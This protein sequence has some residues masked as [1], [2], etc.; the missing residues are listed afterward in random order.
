MACSSL[1]AGCTSVVAWQQMGRTLVVGMVKSLAFVAW[2]QMAEHA[3]KS[4]L[5]AAK[6]VHD[7]PVMSVGK[8]AVAA[9]MGSRTWVSDDFIDRN[10]AS[11]TGNS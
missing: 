11:Y 10:F 8:M 5:K 3:T 7:S 6:T 1:H 4:T 2:A 9:L